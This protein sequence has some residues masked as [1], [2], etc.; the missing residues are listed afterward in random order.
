MRGLARAVPL[1]ALIAVGCG[2][3][4]SPSQN[5]TE[6]FTGTLAP[7]GGRTFHTFTS[8]AGGEYSVLVTS[9]TPVSN[10]FF[11]IGFGQVLSDGSCQLIQQNNL[12]V[13]N[14]IALTGTIVKGTF[15]VAI[16]DI[17][18]FTTTETYTLKVS[19]P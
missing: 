8:S 16:Y 3:V 10:V 9:L 4:V 11:G 18:A 12:S 14:N 13:V 19:H 6:E 7:G 17:G 2:G 1:L 15:C 5:K